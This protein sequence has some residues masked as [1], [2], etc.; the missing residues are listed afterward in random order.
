MVRAGAGVLAACA[1]HGTAY[2]MCHP[3]L[4]R[5]V[6]RCCVRQVLE[7]RVLVPHVCLPPV[8][9]SGGHPLCNNQACTVE[10]GPYANHVPALHTH[11]SPACGGPACRLQSRAAGPRARERCAPRAHIFH[12]CRSIEC[13]G[14][15]L[16][17]GI[18]RRK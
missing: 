9:S 11:C 13:P 18:G 8:R 14:L 4:S 1:L 7:H 15:W 6:F 3:S 16:R 5:G 2:I 10:A 12:P 17:Q